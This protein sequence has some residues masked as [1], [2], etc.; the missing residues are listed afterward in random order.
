MVTAR[1]PDGSSAFGKIAM[2]GLRHGA[3]LCIIAD[4]IKMK[5]VFLYQ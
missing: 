5:N 4:G 2:T 3:D 1:P